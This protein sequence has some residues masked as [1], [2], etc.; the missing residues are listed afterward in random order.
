[1]F[2]VGGLAGFALAPFLWFKLPE[3]LPPVHAEAT[4]PAAAN[5]PAAAEN[6]ASFRDL[7]KKP[8]PL[9]ALGI[10]IAS[11]MGLLLVY[12]LNTW[13]PSSWPPQATP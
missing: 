7:A 13:L 9:V 12:G 3:T 8:Y 1:M 5:Q 6:R 2:V 4:A 10:A 11:F